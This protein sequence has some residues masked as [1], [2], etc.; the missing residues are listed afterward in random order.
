MPSPTIGVEVLILCPGRGRGAEYCDQ[1]V[2]VRVGLSASYS[3]LTRL[4]RWTDLHESF[5][6]DPMWTWLGPPLA[7]W[8]R[9][10]YFRFYG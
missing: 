4:N 9:V 5:C 7:A 2:S 6:T 3:I 10:M 1:L 8:R